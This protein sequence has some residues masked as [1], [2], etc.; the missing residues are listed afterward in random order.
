MYSIKELL[1][2]SF[3]GDEEKQLDFLLDKGLIAGLIGEVPL[4]SLRRILGKSTPTVRLLILVVR[5][6]LLNKFNFV[7]GVVLKAYS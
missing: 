5:L 3:S 7:I 6:R 1:N 2:F 4:E